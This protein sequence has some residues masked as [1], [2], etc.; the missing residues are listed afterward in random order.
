MKQCD[1]P[2]LHQRYILSEDLPENHKTCIPGSTEH[3]H[4]TKGNKSTRV[5]GT[6]YHHRLSFQCS[7]RP[8]TV[9][10]SCS[11]VQHRSLARHPACDFP[12][13]GRWYLSPVFPVFPLVPQLQESLGIAHIA[14]QRSQWLPACLRHAGMLKAKKNELLKMKNHQITAQIAP[15]DCE[16]SLI[17]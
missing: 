8:P 4:E 3:I 10:P 11:L 16:P 7:Q 1:I 15:E 12:M 9:V 5:V 6:G 14:L 2:M 13:S 17:F